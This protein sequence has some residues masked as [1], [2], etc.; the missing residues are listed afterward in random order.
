VVGGYGERRRGA[1]RALAE[2]L[3]THNPGQIR[4]A[5]EMARQ[6]PQLPRLSSPAPPALPH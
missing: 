5:L 4:H 3:R 1:S 2:G 6:P